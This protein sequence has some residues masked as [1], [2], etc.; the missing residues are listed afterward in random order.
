MRRML[1]TMVATMLMVVDGYGSES[2]R[3]NNGANDVPSELSMVADTLDT[4]VKLNS[5][6]WTKS[7]YFNIAYLFPTMI[8]LAEF[9]EYDTN[10]GV[11]F[12]LGYDRVN[13]KGLGWGVLFQGNV[14]SYDF[15]DKT[16]YLM[17]FYLAPQFVLKIGL[18]KNKFYLLQRLGIGYSINKNHEYT[19]HGIGENGLWGMEYCFTKKLAIS[20]NLSYQYTLFIHTPDYIKEEYGF[21]SIG[22]LSYMIGV[23]WHF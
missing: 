14:C 23:D 15:Y 8:S 12:H 2:V 13:R 16:K 10:S 6:S 18:I 3:S 11:D 19:Y 9:D 4:T 17:S 7:I 20:L 5:D 1:F 21:S 22:R